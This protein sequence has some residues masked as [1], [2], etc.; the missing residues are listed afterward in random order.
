MRS[1]AVS[2]QIRIPTRQSTL[3]V[4]SRETKCWNRRRCVRTASSAINC[5]K[6]G[7]RDK[8]RERDRVIGRTVKHGYNTSG[9][10]WNCRLIGRLLC[11]RELGSLAS[12]CADSCFIVTFT[13]HFIKYV[14]KFSI[15]CILLFNR[16]KPTG[17]V[18]HQQFYI[19]Q[20]YALPTVLTWSGTRS[21]DLL[22]LFNFCPS[23][24]HLNL[25]GNSL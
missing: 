11:I 1:F 23:S 4:D 3:Y 7:E 12:Q 19:Q 14:M 21:A 25:Y 9:R 10:D 22:S 24:W 16:L 8:E 20:L 5:F 2:A 17:Y 15:P 18:M 6:T 13:T